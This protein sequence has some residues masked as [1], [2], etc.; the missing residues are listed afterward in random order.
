MRLQRADAPIAGRAETNRGLPGP[1]LRFFPGLPGPDRVLVGGGYAPPCL[2]IYGASPA[3]NPG[4]TFVRTKVNRKSASPLWA[5]PRLLSNR[6]PTKEHCAATET[7]RFGWSLVIGAVVVLLRLPAL[8]M[9]GLS[10]RAIRIDGSIPSKGHQAKLDEIPATDQ[11]PEGLSSSV[12]EH[13][14]SLIK[15][16]WIKDSKT[17][18][19]ACFWVLFARAKSTRGLGGAQPP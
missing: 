13:H 3:P 19:L 8:G 4:F 9:I 11:I 2:G 18:V 1:V 7:P 6:T 14:L 17:L 15:T 12:A 16:D 10:G 5:G